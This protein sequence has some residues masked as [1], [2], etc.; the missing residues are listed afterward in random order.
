M[1]LLHFYERFVYFNKEFSY[2]KLKYIINIIVTSPH[3][4]LHKLSEI[5]IHCHTLPQNITAAPYLI[6]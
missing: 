2:E 3:T 4:T 5:T 6:T 1:K